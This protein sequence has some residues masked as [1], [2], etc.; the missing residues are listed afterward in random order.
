LFGGQAAH[1]ASDRE[2]QQDEA[3]STSFTIDSIRE[4]IQI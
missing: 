2:G 1:D 4:L 3:L